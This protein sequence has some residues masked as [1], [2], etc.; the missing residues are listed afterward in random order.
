M[1]D[2]LPEFFLLVCFGFFAVSLTLHT[3][4]VKTGPSLLLVT[5]GARWE[6]LSSFCLLHLGFLGRVKPR[7]A[8]AESRGLRPSPAFSGLACC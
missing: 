5:Q 2:S 3:V 4:T 8:W 1:V 6:G 7:R